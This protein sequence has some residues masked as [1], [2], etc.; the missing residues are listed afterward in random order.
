MLDVLANGKDK[1]T[2][3]IQFER[4]GGNN[5]KWKLKKTRDNHY[6]IV[7]KSNGLCLDVAEG[8]FKNGTNIQVW[9]PNDTKAQKFRLVSTR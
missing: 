6:Y 7:S 1:G 4:N 3:V 5:Q 2:N 8:L 9:E